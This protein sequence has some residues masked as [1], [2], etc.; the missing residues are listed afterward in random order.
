MTKF[1]CFDRISTF[2]TFAVLP[3]ITPWPREVLINPSGKADVHF[4]LPSIE[5]K[6]GFGFAASASG[7][8]RIGMGPS[9]V[10]FPM[11]GV[12]ITINPMMNAEVRAMGTL[13]MPVGSL[14]Q[15]STQLATQSHVSWAAKS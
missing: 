7:S 11:P 8:A 10:I 9:L 2:A 14:L 15:E 6:H 1:C 13:N 3:E 4:D 5:Q 12:P